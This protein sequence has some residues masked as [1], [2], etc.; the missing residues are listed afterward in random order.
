MHFSH[1]SAVVDFVLIFGGTAKNVCPLCSI[2]QIFQ[3][4]G[5]P[6]RARVCT[7]PVSRSRDGFVSLLLPSLGATGEPPPEAC[8]VMRFQ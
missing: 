6:V 2:K 7:Y 8:V 1:P 3:S 4:R 5:S